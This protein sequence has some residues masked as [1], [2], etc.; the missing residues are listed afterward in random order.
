MFCRLEAN[1]FSLADQNGRAHFYR[2]LSNHRLHIRADGSYN[3]VRLK[4]Q[5]RAQRGHLQNR[6]IRF[7]TNEKIREAH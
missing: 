3:A 1:R 4:L 5:I 6:F 7:V 2:H